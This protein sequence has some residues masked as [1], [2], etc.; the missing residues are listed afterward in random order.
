MTQELIFDR[1]LL[2]KRRSSRANSLHKTD[3]FIKHSLDNICEKLGEMRRE[4][5][6]ILNMGSRSGYA[7]KLLEKRE[8]TNLVIET[9]IS[10]ELLKQSTH[11]FKIAMDEKSI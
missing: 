8:G 6:T 10:L 11:P 5:A 2:I 3:F 1:N 9:D 4:F 7:T